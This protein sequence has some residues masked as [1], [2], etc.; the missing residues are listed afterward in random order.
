MKQIKH[1]ITFSSDVAI[2][3]KILW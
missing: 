1:K 2:F 3:T